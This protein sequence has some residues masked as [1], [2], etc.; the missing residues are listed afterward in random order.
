VIEI[1]AASHNMVDDIRELR[2]RVGFARCGGALQVYIL[3][4]AHML[5]RSAS[6]RC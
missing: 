4:E 3:D 5:T 2:D 1:D 6:T